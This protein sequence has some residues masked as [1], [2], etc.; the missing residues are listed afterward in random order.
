MDCARVGVFWRR[1][2]VRGGWDGLWYCC[3]GLG[4]ILDFWDCGMHSWFV[5]NS[6]ILCVYV[7]SSVV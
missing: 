1:T 4:F 3:L 6:E 2:W 5:K 7:Q